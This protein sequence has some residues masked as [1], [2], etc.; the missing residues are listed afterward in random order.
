MIMHTGVLL[1]VW[2][3]VGCPGASHPLPLHTQPTQNIQLSQPHIASH[4]YSPDD[5]TSLQTFSCV[6]FIE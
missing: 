5:A 6:R 4:S 1:D 2:L 3:M